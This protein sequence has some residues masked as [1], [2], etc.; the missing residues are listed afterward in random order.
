MSMD[1]VRR[2]Y[3]VPAKRGGLVDVQQSDGRT[4]RMEITKA[5]HYVWLRVLGGRYARP[6][7]PTDPSLTYINDRPTT[8]TRGSSE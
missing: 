5:T 6:Y 2:T 3:G 4:V 7:H 1:Y 8:P